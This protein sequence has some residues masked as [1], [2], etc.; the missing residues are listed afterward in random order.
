[1]TEL[2]NSDATV[3]KRRKMPTTRRLSDDRKSH[4]RSKITNHADLLPN[5]SHK[6]RMARRFRDLV[7]AFIVDAGGRSLCSEIKI[8]LARRLASTTVLAEELEAR[9]I[10]G[11]AV[12][13]SQLCTLA[14][15]VM[16]LSIRLGLE[17]KATPVP[18]LHDQ[19]GLLDQLARETPLVIVEHAE[20]INDG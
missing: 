13:I 9:M 17:R 19:G 2:L 10:D 18:G 4:G 12:D 7:N 14:S 5:I 6:S 3:A 16:R 1:M 20:S 11:V 8:G 15:T